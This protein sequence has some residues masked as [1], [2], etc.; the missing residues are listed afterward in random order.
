M[1]AEQ[2]IQREK[3]ES[4]SHKMSTAISFGTAILGA[5]LGRKRLSSA[6]AN[7]VG[8]AMRKAGSASKQA[9]D[10]K[11]AQQTAEKVRVDLAAL[12]EKLST[13]VEALSDS[14]SAQDV[15]LTEIPVRPKSTDIHI[16][17]IGLAWLPYVEEADG[18]LRAAWRS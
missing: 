4:S 1:R 11:R 13:E 5:V 10:V 9:G 18:R 6:T 17:I 3:Q 2:A 7:K 16:P 12:N 8:T 14:F 15:E